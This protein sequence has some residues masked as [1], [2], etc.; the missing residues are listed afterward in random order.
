MLIQAI[1]AYGGPLKDLA[2]TPNIDRIAS[3]V[4]GSTVV[5][6]QTLYQDPAGLLYLPENTVT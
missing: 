3:W 1:S 6:L 5:L 4:C 2:P